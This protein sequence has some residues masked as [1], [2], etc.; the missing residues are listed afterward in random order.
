MG[1]SIGVQGN[2]FTLRSDGRVQH[3]VGLPGTGLRWSETIGRAAPQ[4][5]T[6]A[7]PLPYHPAR[8]AAVQP[9]G[10]VAWYGL[11]LLAV[12]GLVAI[13]AA[14]TPSQQGQHETSAIFGLLPLVMLAAMI[15]P[16]ILYVRSRRRARGRTD[17]AYEG[18]LQTLVNIYSEEVARQ[19]VLGDPWQGATREIIQIMYGPP[20]DTSTHV[21]KTTTR[22]TWK[23]VPIDARRYALRIEF[24]NGACVGWQTA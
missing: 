2:R 10:L 6:I 3:T 14:V 24:E 18:Y 17:A 15:A 7:R 8:P 12:V 1:A 20:N 23:Y 5:R 21:Y 19:M 11:A 22:E 16:A 13:A 9:I 4:T